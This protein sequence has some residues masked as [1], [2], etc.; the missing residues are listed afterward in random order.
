MFLGRE[1]EVDIRDSKII[2]RLLMLIEAVKKQARLIEVI[3]GISVLLTTIIGLIIMW[4]DFKL[5]HRPF[6]EIYPSEF[7]HHPQ[8]QGED[9]SQVWCYLKFKIVNHGR[10]PVYDIK[11]DKLNVTL[12][13]EIDLAETFKSY[14]GNYC[15]FPD[16]PM[17]ITETVTNSKI[18]TE[19]IIKGDKQVDYDIKVRYR[20]PQQRRYYSYSFKGRYER[21]HVN[22]MSTSGN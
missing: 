4:G 6:L 14:F 13:R 2:K 3:I 16:T 20:G 7:S 9:D 12:D 19:E 21:G 8:W 18:N 17:T 11:L 22:T 5:T 15:V 10:V 1:E